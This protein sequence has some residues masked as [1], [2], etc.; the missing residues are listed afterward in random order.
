[1]I[2]Y[3]ILAC[4]EHKELDR[5]LTL[6]VKYVKIPHEIVVILDDGNTTDEVYDVIDKFKNDISCYSHPLNNNFAAQKNFMTLQCK[7][8]WIFNIDAD[9]LPSENLLQT[10]NSLIWA[11][12]ECETYLLPRVNTVEGLTQEHIDKWRWKVNEKGWVNWPDFQMR[13]YR[14]IPQRIKWVRPVHE[15]LEGY[16]TYTTLP[17][18]EAY[19]L[20]HPKE[21]K[22]QEKQ[23]KM[24]EKL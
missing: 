11:N 16:K 3:G 15:I 13:I 17:D 2:S 12:P 9:E 22:K 24:Y 1:M 14:N 5:L 19:C 7:G 8:Q 23:N 6:L 4:N 18:D 20:Y 21:I 10:V